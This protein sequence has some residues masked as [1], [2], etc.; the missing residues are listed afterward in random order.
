MPLIL[1][2]GSLQDNIRNVFTR[3]DYD[4]LPQICGLLYI[5]HEYALV[6]SMEAAPGLSGFQPLLRSDLE[7]AQGIP[8]FVNL[9]G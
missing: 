9:V 2:P 6:L 7:K 4:I 3:E 8:I 1:E 5:F